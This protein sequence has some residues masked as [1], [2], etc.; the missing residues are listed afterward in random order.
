[1]LTTAMSED[2]AN[3]V[4]EQ[5]KLLAQQKLQ[6]E[7]LLD[8]PQRVDPTSRPPQRFFDS[9]KIPDLIKTNPR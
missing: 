8:A 5:E 1:M 9:S 2:L 4:K 6:L 3:K 7:K